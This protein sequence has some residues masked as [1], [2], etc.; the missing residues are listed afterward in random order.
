MERSAAERARAI[1]ADEAQRA[2]RTLVEAL[3]TAFLAEVAQ[4]VARERARLEAPRA[5]LEASLAELTRL[6]TSL[7]ALAPACARAR[8]GLAALAERCESAGVLVP[9]TR[10]E[11]RERRAPGRALPPGPGVGA[12]LEPGGPGAT[13]E[14]GAPL[15]LPLDE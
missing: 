8:S 15:A 5:A 1:L 7:S 13:L 10:L 6:A 11:P 4:T 3:L 9:V 2:A 14:R 12:G